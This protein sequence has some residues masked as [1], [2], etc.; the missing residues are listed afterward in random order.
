MTKDYQV[1]PAFLPYGLPAK[2]KMVRL[3]QAFCQRVL[4]IN[5]SVPWQVHWT[6]LVSSASRIQRADTTVKPGEQPFQYIQATNGIRFGKNV[7][8]GP[9]VRL[10]SANHSLTDFYAH[11]AEEPII[12]DDDCWLGTDVTV[13][14]GVHLAAH[15]VVLDGSVVTRSSLGNCVMA[16]VPAVIIQTLP[17]YGETIT[18]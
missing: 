14:A 1:S 5:R 11:D 13:V 18:E 12:I 8:L 3:F 9:G 4:G 7:H 15:T 2:G 10:V 17:P 6:S 16:G